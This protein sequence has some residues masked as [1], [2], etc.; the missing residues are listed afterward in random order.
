MGL[1][2]YSV[3]RI[4]IYVAALYLER[5]SSDADAILRSDQ[6]KLL[7]VRFVHDVDEA[8][9]R[10]AWTDGFDGNCTAPC[11]LPPGEV[12]RFL[13]AVPAFRRGDGSTLL[14]EHG[15]VRISVDGRLLGTVTDP[16]FAQVIL[17]TFIG[18]VPPTD[19]L[20]RDLLGLR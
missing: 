2:T 11:H 1:R 15:T 9:A 8:S 14:F 7:E 12:S 5:P 3:F 18:S 19:R 16:I 6:T 13:D 17:A 10:K 4:H 20:K